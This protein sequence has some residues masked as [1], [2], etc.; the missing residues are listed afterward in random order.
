MAAISSRKAKSRRF[1]P[2]F[3]FSGTQCSLELE[4]FFRNQGKRWIIG[5][6]EAGRG[7][8]AGEVLAGAALLP[9][10]FQHPVLNDSKKLK[11]AQREAIY[12]ELLRQAEATK[13]QPVAERIVLTTGVATV[14]EIDSLNILRATH[15]AMKR[16]AEALLLQ[17][18]G[19]AVLDTAAASEW[20]FLIDG[21]PVP[22]TSFP[23]PQQSVVKGDSLCLSI[24]AASIAAKVTRD[25]QM[26]EAATRFPAYEFNKH[27]GYGTA[28][29]LAAL[30]KYGP[31][32]IHRKS[33]APVAALL[34][35][36]ADEKPRAYL[37][38][39]LDLG[40]TPSSPPRRKKK[41]ES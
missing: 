29:H 6:D 38:A 35:G 30:A 40:E 19:K 21:L 18:T 41:A 9:A 10:D 17:L 16:A 37:Q 24:A 15:L 4:T 34:P 2:G 5:V 23:W 1:P 26:T 36:A 25:R 20:I 32:P 31:C 12:E 27:K 33:F 13:T 39:E 11:E 3:S 28:L 14:A 22:T 8:L 7:P